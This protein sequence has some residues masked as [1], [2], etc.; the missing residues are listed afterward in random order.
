MQ[1]NS[2]VEFL[3][4]NYLEFESSKGVVNSAEKYSLCFNLLKYY[5]ILKR[6]FI[7]SLKN[8]SICKQYDQGDQD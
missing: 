6:K 7:Q 5:I 3:Y 4:M 8:G 1:K 2:E